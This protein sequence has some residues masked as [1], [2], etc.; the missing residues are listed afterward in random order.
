MS[1]ILF[2]LLIPLTILLGCTGDPVVRTPNMD[3]L[4]AVGTCFETTDAKSALLKSKALFAVWKGKVEETAYRRGG[5][6]PAGCG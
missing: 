1:R 2:S 5:P 6:R 4:A 3:A